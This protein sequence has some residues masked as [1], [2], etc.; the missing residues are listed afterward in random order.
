MTPLHWLGDF[1]LARF[2][3]TFS[4]FVVYFTSFDLLLLL[5]LSALHTLSGSKCNLTG[6][7]R[8]LLFSDRLLF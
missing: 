6:F 5:F 8:P 3:L 2:K 1:F 4:F 7:K